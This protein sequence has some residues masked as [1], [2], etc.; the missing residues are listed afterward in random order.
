MFSD[1]IVAVD[2]VP[3]G[4]KLVAGG[5]HDAFLGPKIVG[6]MTI[7]KQ[8]IAGLETGPPIPDYTRR[9]CFAVQK[10][11]RELL[12]KLNQGLL[13]VKTSGEYDRLYEKWLGIEDPW[14]RYARYFWPVTGTLLAILALWALFYFVRERRQAEALGAINA[15]LRLAKDAA[16][17]SAI[18]QRTILDSI[19]D[20]VIVTDTAGRIEFINR[21]AESFTGWSCNEALGRPLDE[22]FPI[23]DEAT[24]QPSESPLVRVL[25]TKEVGGFAGPTLLRTR[26]AAD[27]PIS[28]SSAPILRDD[29]ELSGVVLVFRDDST[30]RAVQK[31]LLESETRFRLLAEHAQDWVTVKDA[32]GHFTYLSPSCEQ[33]TGYTPEEFIEDDGLMARLLHPDDRAR[34]INHLHQDADDV[35]DLE[36]RLRHRDGHEIWIAHRCRAMRDEAG[37][38]LGRRGSNRDITARKCAERALQESEARYRSAVD[39]VRDAFIVMDGDSGQVTE[40]NTAA[41]RMFGYPQAEMLGRNLL[42]ILVPERY[43]EAHRRALP[44][45]A[46]TGEGAAINKTQEWMAQHRDGHEFPIELSLTAY[47]QEEGHW[48]AVGLA[49]DITE[50][51]QAE[52]ALRESEEKFRSIYLGAADGMVLIDAADGHIIEANPAFQALLGYTQD[53][54]TAKHIWELR[55][56]E[57]REL[58]RDRF[59][60]V[61]QTGQ[62]RFNDVPLQTRGGEV[63]PTDV[64]SHLI[65]Y[66]GRQAILSIARDMREQAAARRKLEER[67]DEL[68]RFQDVAIG[69]E[70]RM[71]ALVEENARLLAR[72][73]VLEKK[74]S[75]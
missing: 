47:Q 11:N 38:F 4:M 49:R 8:H 1:E 54:L 65:P 44:H 45:F 24:R 41:E 15:D 28:D 58:A 43:R 35:A 21:R 70:L 16:A 10:G 60:G 31:S 39:S 34:Y 64:I 2:T 17:A 23:M 59:N 42:E 63:V 29:D 14:R 40:W 72:L 12:E 25:R 52:L 71:K 13:I 67:L 37:N 18:R 51:K 75:A 30:V 61:R 5:Q 6:R 56:P 62:M 74:G 46:K 50:R 57:A 53:E 55:P 26:D 68:R 7:N 20:A 19:G 33:M 22:V 32:H 27:L 9:F 3:E 73:S 48:L 66:Q 36:L 69:R